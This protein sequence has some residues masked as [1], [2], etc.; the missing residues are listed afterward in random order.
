MVK[1]SEAQARLIHE[2]RGQGQGYKAVAHA[3]G[4][5]RDAVRYFCKRNGL[6]NNDFKDGGCPNCGKLIVQPRTGRKKRFCDERCRRAW[7]KRHPSAVQQNDGAVYH[8]TCA[9][10]GQPF[11]SYGNRHRLYCSRNC[12][13][14]NRFAQSGHP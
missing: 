3:T 5:N 13:F 2:L 9:G 1:I 14:M 6:E 8:L 11:D 7:W 4:L 10:C 12:Y